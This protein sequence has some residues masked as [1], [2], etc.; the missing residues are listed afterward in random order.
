[1]NWC[2][3]LAIF[4]AALGPLQLG[5]NGS[6][7]NQ[8]Q[9]EIELFLNT[10]FKERYDFQLTTNSMPT[11]FSFVVTIYT[12]GGLVGA[13]YCC[14]V[15]DNIG[16]RNGI[17]FTQLFSV[18]GAILQGCCKYASSYEM[19]LLGRLLTGFSNGLLEV[20]SPLY[21]VEISP[22]H[23]RGAAGIVNAVGHSAGVLAVSILGLSNILGGK[24]YWP[25]LLALPLVPS[26]L[27]IAILPFIP[28]SPRY[29]F[30][31]KRRNSEAK[32]A[33][34]KLRNTNEVSMDMFSLRLEE[35]SYR[36]DTNFTILELICSKKH[37]LALF[38]GVCLLLS[39]SMTGLYILKSYSTSFFTSV[40]LDIEMSVYLTFAMNSLSVLV[41]LVAIPLIDQVGRRTLQLTGIGG[42]A[43]CLFMIT[44][45]LNLESDYDGTIVVS[46]VLLTT[47]F[48][49][50]G[51]SSIPWVATGELFT[52][53]PR[54]AATSIC[55]SLDW[56]GSTI[57]LLLFLQL[58]IH[59]F[60]WSFIPLLLFSVLFIILGIIYLPETKN[61][62]S[63]VISDLFQDK[64]WNTAIGLIKTTE[65]DKSSSD[66]VSKFY[67]NYESIP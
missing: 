47:V 53:G 49:G 67:K 16:R 32:A 63:R 3:V 19:L 36:D 17:I 1:M 18:F 14:I 13:L 65:R 39:K 66:S 25:T 48:Y 10:T 8:P 4:C 15:A 44:V 50:I 7:I 43:F 9:H 37:Q 35:E 60:D 58:M 24:D 59:A 28:E 64:G 46:F 2:F 30:I 33:L 42:V 5:Y 56:A 45:G 40:G 11:Y 57:M 21:L 23:I 62:S 22:I 12:V 51:P 52:Q 31:A 41:T 61:R 55:I 54:G 6:V 34:V 29:L 27:Q 38:V 20:I 26:F